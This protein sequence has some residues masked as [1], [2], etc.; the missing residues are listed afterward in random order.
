[1]KIRRKT[2][3]ILF[4]IHSRLPNPLVCYCLSRAKNFSKLAELPDKVNIERLV[5]HKARYT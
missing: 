2:K 4:F 1:M 5:L 3:L